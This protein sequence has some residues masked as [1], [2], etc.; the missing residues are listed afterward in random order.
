VVTTHNVLRVNNTLGP[1]IPASVRV[2]AWGSAAG[3]KDV[4]CLA[5]LQSVAQ[6]PGRTPHRL[7][8]GAVL[9]A[10]IG[11]HGRERILR[12]A[13]RHTRSSL[14]DAEDA[15]ASVNATSQAFI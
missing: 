3:S 8:A 4:E 11:E 9:L 1:E 6:Q 12:A 14:A 2:C 7:E 13:G 10:E 5:L 15:N